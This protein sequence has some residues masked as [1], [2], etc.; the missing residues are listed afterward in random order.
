MDLRIEIG[1]YLSDS[2]HCVSQS[3]REKD[4]EKVAMFIST[5]S[6]VSSLRR[7]SSTSKVGLE[8]D[9]LFTGASGSQTQP[10]LHLLFGAF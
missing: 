9:H 10:S 8:G 5:G 6:R 2:G 7:G 3:H 1:K 4:P